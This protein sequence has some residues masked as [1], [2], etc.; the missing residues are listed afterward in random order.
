MAASTSILAEKL[1]EYPQQ[2]VIDG[3]GDAT[4]GV[5]DSC[6]EQNDGVL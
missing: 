6:L 3:S 1:H 2:E 4:S 5:L